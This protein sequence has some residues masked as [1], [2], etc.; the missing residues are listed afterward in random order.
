MDQCSRFNPA[1]ANCLSGPS[2]T[3]V[4]GNNGSSLPHIFSSRRYD[5]HSAIIARTS[6]PTGKKKV[7]KVLLN[8][9]FIS[10]ASWLM[11]PAI[12]STCLSFNEAMALS[13]APVS[14]VKAT[15]ARFRRSISVTVG[16]LLM[17]YLICSSVGTFCCRF[18]VA[19][20]VSL[21]DRLK[22][23]ASTYW[24]RDL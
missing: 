20:R 7:L 9:V 24:I 16:I 4:A 22:Y 15:R 2:A 3:R 18:A 12:K 19:T 17:T 23:S 21:A 8:F 10:R 14:R 11:Q 5:I 1:A 6:S 13:L